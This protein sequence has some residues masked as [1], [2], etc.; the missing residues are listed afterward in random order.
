MSLK[1]W[2]SEADPYD[3][4]QLADNFLKL[5]QHDHTPGQGSQIPASG[6]APNAVTGDKISPH[7]I[8]VSQLD[9]ALTALIGSRGKSIVSATESRTNT[10]YGLLATPDQV[11]GIVLPTDGLI[12]VAYQA[13][14]QESVSG[15]AN[16][17]IFVG[18]NQLKIASTSTGA[19]ST[20]PPSAGI[21]GTAATNR[22][23]FSQ[24]S[25]LGSINTGAAYTSDV[26]TGQAI[27][28][29]TVNNGD[30]CYIFADADTY[31]I[32]IQFKASSGSVTA[33]NRKLWVWTI[34][35]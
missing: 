21:G 27:G 9:P 35:F 12:A 31:D 14:W 25:G 20:V 26:T 30:V 15:A 2:N 11:T 10:A 18:T 13:T 24:G 23:L 7:S 3:H 16:A 34:G 1:V 33:K 6:L 29:A 17:A 5:D 8:G 19:P 32:S 22:P 4:Q 28:V